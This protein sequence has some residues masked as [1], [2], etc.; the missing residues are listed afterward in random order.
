MMNDAD[1]IKTTNS[2][3][4][5]HEIMPHVLPFQGI[6]ERYCFEPNHIVLGAM[7]TGHVCIIVEDAHARPTTS[8]QTMNLHPLRLALQTAP[9]ACAQASGQLPLAAA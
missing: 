5:K 9:L 6:H 7:K 3:V 2:R 8:A 1:V 4:L